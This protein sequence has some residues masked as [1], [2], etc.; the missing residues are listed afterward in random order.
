MISSMIIKGI[1]RK[2]T[3]IAFVISAVWFLPEALFAKGAVVAY[4]PG[5]GVSNWANYPSN[6]QNE[7]L[8]FGV[9]VKSI[10]I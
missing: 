5:K 10:K 6:D 3:A 7:K 1:F 4:A 9:I 2:H 8:I